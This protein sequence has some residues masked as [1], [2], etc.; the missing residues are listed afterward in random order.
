MMAPNA[1]AGLIERFDSHREMYRSG[2]YNETQLRRDFLDP[3][4]RALG[5]DVDNKKGYAEC[6]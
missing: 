3:L 4:F 6:P 1:L 2:R 5:W